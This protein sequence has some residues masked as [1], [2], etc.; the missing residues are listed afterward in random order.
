MGIKRL[1][2]GM[3]RGYRFLTAGGIPRCRFYP[4]CSDYAL[5]ALEQ[6]GIMKGLPCMLQRIL[7]CHPWNAGGYDPLDT[8][9][10]PRS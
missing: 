1:L 3:I 10:S 8:V 5:N 7:R 4:T 6:K 2:L 9:Q